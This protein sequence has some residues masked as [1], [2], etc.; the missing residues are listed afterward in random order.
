MY[1]NFKSNDDYIVEE[2]GTIDVKG[3]G[4]IT[5]YW[6]SGKSSLIGLSSIATVGEA[7]ISTS[8]IKRVSSEEECTEFE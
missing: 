4:N 6:L 5:T 8:I 2:R 7:N 3:K 1:K